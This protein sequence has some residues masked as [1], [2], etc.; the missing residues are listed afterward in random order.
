M[1]GKSGN[2]FAH[3]ALVPLLLSVGISAAGCGLNFCPGTAC[4][5]NIL[6]GSNL[7]QAT[8]GGDSIVVGKS[9]TFAIGQTVAFVAVL[10]ENA[11]A[12]TLSLEVSGNDRN[13]A[14]TYSV[15]SASSRQLAG[16]VGAARLKTLGVTRPGSYTWRFLRGEKLLAKGTITEK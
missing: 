14:L 15:R 6:F 12:K 11:G 4:G 8:K 10:S 2:W 1:I 13:N 7:K 5:G 16:I 3:L 9:D